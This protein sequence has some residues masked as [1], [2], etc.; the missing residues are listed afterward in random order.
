MNP[1]TSK[2]NHIQDQLMTQL[3][4]LATVLRKSEVIQQDKEGGKMYLCD[5]QGS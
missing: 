2:G 1:Q 3:I 5:Q 4:Y